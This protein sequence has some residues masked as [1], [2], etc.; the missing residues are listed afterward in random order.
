MANVKNG[1]K[2]K[3]KPTEASPKT[4]TR[5][6]A[7]FTAASMLETAGL[8][9]PDPPLWFPP[10]PTPVEPM[11]TTLA[12]EDLQEILD[13]P[14]AN[15][16]DIY[17]TAN[18]ESDDPTDAII[19]PT[20]ALKIKLPTS[21]KE[22]SSSVKTITISKWPKANTGK[23]P[24]TTEKN[25][26]AAI[27]LEDDE[28][29]EEA[30]TYKNKQCSTSPTFLALYF[31]YYICRNCAI[32]AASRGHQHPTN[33]SPVGTTFTSAVNAILM[34]VPCNIPWQPILAYKLSSAAAKIP[35]V[36]LK[37]DEDWDGLQETI[38]LAEGGKKLKGQSPILVNIE[39]GPSGV[40]TIYFLHDIYSAL[41]IF[42]TLNHCVRV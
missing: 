21:R 42:S 39:L 32:G 38:I 40:S 35:Y 34:A 3:R 31:S 11:D 14:E 2:C 7:C 9:H 33:H 41:C 1:K 29:D 5:K 26:G 15:S 22:G 24:A 19:Q 8:S 4:P 16:T 6:S 23:H 10:S 20:S 13:D 18:S 30:E 17:T 36:T 12:D 27:E 37:M 25:K 28:H